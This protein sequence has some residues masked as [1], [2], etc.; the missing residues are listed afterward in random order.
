MHIGLDQLPSHTAVE[1]GLQHIQWE[2]DFS[3]SKG[4]QYPLQYYIFT[5]QMH[6]C[7]YQFSKCSKT[8]SSTF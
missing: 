5:Q 1:L 7:S 2:W 3:L 4:K 8:L 6:V